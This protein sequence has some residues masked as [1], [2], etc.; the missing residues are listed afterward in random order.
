MILLV[1][2]GVYAYIQSAKE[3]ELRNAKAAKLSELNNLL[4]SYNFS[5]TE[6]RG[7]AIPYLVEAKN[8]IEAATT[9]QEVNSVNVKMYFDRAVSAYQNCVKEKEQL[10]YEAELNQTKLQ[11]IQDIEISFQPLLSLNLPDS[12]KSKVVATMKSLE[13]KVQNAKTIEEVQGINVE[14]YLLSLWRE[15]YFWK[16]DNVPGNEVVLQKGEVKQLV[17]KDEAK[18]LVEGISNYTELLQY[19]VSKVEY[20][21]IALT[22]PREQIAGGFLQPGDR[23]SI[24]VT[25]STNRNIRTYREVVDMAYVEFVLLPVDAGNI[26][27]RE[28]QSETSS[29]GSSSSVTYTEGHSFSYDL[30]GG[31]PFS[32]STSASD[33]YSNSQSATQTSSAGYTY[34]VDLAEILKAIAAGKIQASDEVKAQLESYGWKLV[35]LEQSS[36]MLVLSPNTKFLIIIRVP[37][38]F[39]PDILQNPTGVY[40][41]K[42]S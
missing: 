12:L 1:S 9:V 4:T 27:A 13:E 30:G 7:K 10:A 2:V 17:S 20:V 40:I 39:V 29:T 14:P 23:I 33:T 41:A 42:I 37:S 19:R 11:K 26:N 24:F 6:C 25:N 32:N 18:M 36:N 21:E 35:T 38:V 34:R 8:K 31:A 22:L 16:I 5:D 15:Y 28:S 3:K